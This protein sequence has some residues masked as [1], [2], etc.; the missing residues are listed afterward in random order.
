[1]CHVYRSS[2]DVSQRLL[3]HFVQDVADLNVTL[4]HT[5][6]HDN[7]QLTLTRDDDHAPNDR[8]IVVVLSLIHI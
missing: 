2:D 4:R 8:R 6:T 1:M 3:K 5:P 7:S